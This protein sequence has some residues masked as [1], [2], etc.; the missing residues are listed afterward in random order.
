M[1]ADDI[2]TGNANSILDKHLSDEVDVVMLG[3]EM[4]DCETLQ[5]DKENWYMQSLTKEETTDQ[6]KLLGLTTTCAKFIKRSLIE[7]NNIRFDVIRF[8][9]DTVFMTKVALVQSTMMVCP[10][11]MWYV[12]AIRH[13]S[14]TNTFTK[15]EEI[16]HF[17]TD[18]QKF[19]MVKTSGLHHHLG[20]YQMEHLRNIRI[21]TLC[22][23]MPIIVKMWS[24]GMLFNKSKYDPVSVSVVLKTLLHTIWKGLKNSFN[25]K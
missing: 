4:R 14:L 24:H 7:K 8:H 17:Q 5:L 6:D 23:Q 20:N 9:E 18:L 12:W 3:I 13:G 16:L 2:L 11:D 1:D 15:E 22:E 21:M 25:N 19:I 10:N